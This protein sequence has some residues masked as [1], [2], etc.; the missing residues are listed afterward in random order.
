MAAKTNWG[1]LAIRGGEPRGKAYDSITTPV[2]SSATYVFGST[3]EIARYF[4]GDIERFIGAKML[5]VKRA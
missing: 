4:Q 2:V 5:E 1:T 3:G